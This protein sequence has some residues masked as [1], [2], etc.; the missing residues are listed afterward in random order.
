MAYLFYVDDVELPVTPSKLTTKINN[1]N[2]TISLINY[3]E[4]NI[5][6]APGLTEIEFE[7]MIPQMKHPF[8]NL[9]STLSPNSY[10]TGAFVPEAAAFYLDV[11][12]TLKMSI[13][14]FSFKVIRTNPQ[15][16]LRLFRAKDALDMLVSLEEYSI[17]EDANEGFDLLV[18]V[19]LKQYKQYNTQSLKVVTNN[20]TKSSATVIGTMTRISTVMTPKFYTVKKGDSL[21]SICKKFLGD[22]ALYPKI[23]KLNNL[24]NPGLII[25]G[26]VIYFE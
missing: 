13:K 9:P 22:G 16:D 21:W 23:A 18:S 14:P 6:K 25:P 4:V 8:A 11:F 20:A 17:V 12:E 15:N 19:K 3:D 5:L 10:D 24:A 1:Q 7:A 26:Q 2:Q